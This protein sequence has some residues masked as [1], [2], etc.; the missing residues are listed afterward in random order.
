MTE[1]IKKLKT[2]QMMTI[3]IG[4][5]QVT[6]GHKTEMGKLNDVFEIGN[7]YRIAENKKP[8]SIESFLSLPD[9]WEFIQEVERQL[10]PNSPTGS[11]KLPLQKGSSKIAYSEAVKQFS[12]IKSQR[13]GK[14][15]NRGVWANLYILIK[16]GMYLSPKLEFEIIDVF[17]N[18]K[19]LTHR[20][21]GGE[22]F[23]K[24]NTTMK[25]F[26]E[27]NSFSYSTVS[28]LIREK[29][30]IL[31]TRGYNKKEHNSQIQEYREKIQDYLINLIKM[32]FV[33]NYDELVAVVGKYEF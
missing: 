31:S 5:G 18:S 21:N 27:P 30:E 15:E 1:K 24:L 6:I 11:L 25:E 2:N 12:A 16:A 29:L 8:K 22:A 9:T 19:I 3:Q 28:L 7:C 4:N 26:F 14:P 10:N 13:G 33:K 23:K 17:I 32:D 20:D